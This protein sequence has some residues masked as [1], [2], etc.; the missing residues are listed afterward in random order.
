MADEMQAGEFIPLVAPSFPE[1]ATVAILTER[2]WSMAV[3]IGSESQLRLVTPSL[4]RLRLAAAILNDER[5]VKTRLRA[6]MTSDGCA[7]ENGPKTLMAMIWA[8]LAIPEEV[9]VMGAGGLGTAFGALPAAELTP[10]GHPP[11]VT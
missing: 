2:S 8:P 9:L 5:R 1:A 10:P 11:P 6:A 3:F 4:P 7:V